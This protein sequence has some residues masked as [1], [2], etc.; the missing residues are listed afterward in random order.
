MFYTDQ[1]SINNNVFTYGQGVEY[2]YTMFKLLN[3]RINPILPARYLLIGRCEYFQE[4]IIGDVIG[5]VVQLDIDGIMR[6]C[7]LNTNNTITRKEKSDRFKGTILYCLIH[8]LLHIEQNMAT[9]YSFGLDD[10]TTEI[11][12]EESCHCN[13]AYTCNQLIESDILMAEVIPPVS[14]DIPALDNFIPWIEED[15]SSDRLVQAYQSYYRIT[16]PY[17]KVLWLMNLLLF[18]HEEGFHPS[19]STPFK[20]HEYMNQGYSSVLLNIFVN[21]KICRTGYLIYLNYL[22][23]PFEIMKLLDLMIL[24]QKQGNDRITYKNL[25]NKN[26]PNL[27]II[28]VEYRGDDSLL[29]IVKQIPSN[30]FPVPPIM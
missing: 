12:I 26:F 6:K 22:Q 29:E 7:I 4:G 23:P 15:D 5:D 14:L 1:L 10:D 28:E 24:M 11:L 19:I 13:T 20:L 18:S 3:G 27:M 2:A 21:Q 16:N 25:I 30:E 17:E 9:Y 8:E